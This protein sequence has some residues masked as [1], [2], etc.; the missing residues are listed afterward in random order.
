MGSVG[1][2]ESKPGASAATDPGSTPNP[3][4]VPQAPAPAAPP[5][6]RMPKARNSRAAPRKPAEKRGEGLSTWLLKSG[7]ETF[8]STLVKLLLVVLFVAVALQF[9]LLRW[10]VDKSGA[11][12]RWTTDGPEI[13]IERRKESR[14]R[15]L[16]MPLTE[17]SHSIAGT[18]IVVKIDLTEPK[19]DSFKGLE[20]FAEGKGNPLFSAGEVPA[21]YFEW[22]SAQTD[23]EMN[24]AIE[25]EGYTPDIAGG[26]NT[27]Q[28]GV[29][30]LVLKISEYSPKGQKC[31][32]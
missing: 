23:K 32:L 12:V 30:V 9:G 13:E 17:G 1:E 20:V 21:K 24:C 5:A 15:T 8:G 11:K 31:P 25:A 27:P 18:S 19:K 29:F 4:D 14:K 28:D 16:L 10:F 26:I 7:A 6:S 22:N 2:K 3:A